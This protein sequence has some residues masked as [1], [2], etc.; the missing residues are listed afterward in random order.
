MRRPERNTA[1]D[2]RKAIADIRVF[3]LFEYEILS[4]TTRDGTGHAMTQVFRT[5]LIG[6]FEA[7]HYGHEGDRKHA[8][9]VTRA[10]VVS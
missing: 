10:L 5:K 3:H 1:A 4:Y 2:E 6:Y 7:A 9:I 8:D